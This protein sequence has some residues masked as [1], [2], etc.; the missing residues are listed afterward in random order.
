MR[1]AKVM[2]D[3]ISRKFAPVLE[4]MVE[5]IGSEPHVKFGDALERAAWACGFSAIPADVEWAL[6]RAAMKIA[7]HERIEGC[8][9][10]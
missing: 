4:R 5:I 7:V 3:S 8:P 10:A 1:S 9:D 6:L 2:T